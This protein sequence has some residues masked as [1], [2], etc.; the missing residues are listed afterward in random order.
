MKPSHEQCAIA[1][2]V[3][4]DLHYADK[5]MAINRFYR[6]SMGKLRNA[7]A[8]FNE[9]GPAFIIELGDLIDKADKEA[10]TGF[11]ATIDAVYQAFEGKR[12]YV[13]GNH[14]VATYSKSEFLKLIGEDR[15]FYSFDSGGYHFIVLD[16]NFHRDGSSYNAGD[17]DWAETYVPPPQMEWLKGDLGRAGG[18]PSIVFTHQNLHDETNPHGVK[19]APEVRRILED[20]GIV[21]A[22][23]Q[24]HDHAGGFARINGIPYLTFRAE[25]DGSGPENN[26]YAMVYVLKDG[27]IQVEGYGKQESFEL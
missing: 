4:A 13:L 26:A 9:L 7:V 16:A 3:I 18:A 17:F 8:A 6:E 10:E 19:N 25:V 15:A 14:D 24:G 12:Y 20:A 23:F 27:T 11:L 1:F 22:F 2:G 5:D 21:R